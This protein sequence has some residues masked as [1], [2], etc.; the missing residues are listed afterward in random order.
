MFPGSLPP[1]GRICRGQAKPIFLASSSGPFPLGLFLRAC[2][3][4]HRT[5]R[6]ACGDEPF[7]PGPLSLPCLNTPALDPLQ[8]GALHASTHDPRCTGRGAAIRLCLPE[9]GFQQKPRRGLPPLAAYLC[10]QFCRPAI[11]VFDSF[12]VAC[13]LF[14]NRTPPLVVPALFQATANVS[15]DLSPRP[16]GRTRNARG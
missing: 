15:P 13:R 7:S 10:L 6:D 12:G 16:P 2:S 8:E 14:E 1:P 9:T 3:S 4:Q 5:A 11:E